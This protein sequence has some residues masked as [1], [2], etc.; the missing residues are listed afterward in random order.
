MWFGGSPHRGILNIVAGSGPAGLVGGFHFIP[1]PLDDTLAAYAR[2]RESSPTV[3]YPC[4][5][6][7]RD[8]YAFMA[9][10]MSRLHYLSTGQTIQ[11]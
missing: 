8:Q 10:S 7:G 3:F 1:L 11:L 9:R 4:H 2:E 6:T 5:C